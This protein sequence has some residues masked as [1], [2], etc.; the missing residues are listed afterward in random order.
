M[1]RTFLYHRSCPSGKIF[2]D[3]DEYDQAKKEGWVSAPW[4]I[5]QKPD[6]PVMEEIPHKKGYPA[7]RKPRKSKGR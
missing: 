3:Q 5:N 2:D 1:Y 7:K 6:D 4:L